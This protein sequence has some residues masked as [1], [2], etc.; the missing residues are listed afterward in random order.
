LGILHHVG[1]EV[2]LSEARRLL[3]PG[4]VC[5]FLEP[6]GSSALVEGIKRRIHAALGPRLGLTRVTS[7]EENL[8]LKDIRRETAGWAYRRIYTFRLTYRARKLFLPRLL[9]DCSLRLDHF[10]LT[11]LPPLQ[12]FAGAA[13]ISLR[14]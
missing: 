3:R 13:V 10:L 6:L 14:K 1:L 2:G 11:I 5:V 12:H 8:R 7:G 4:G 9:W